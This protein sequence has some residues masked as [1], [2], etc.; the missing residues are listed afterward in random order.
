MRPAGIG[1]FEKRED[2]R[3]NVYSFEQKEIAF[4]EPFTGIFKANSKAWDYFQAQPAYYRK[5]A[6][7]WVISAKQEATKQKR[8]ETL[9]ADSVAGLHVKQLRRPEKK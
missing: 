5:A 2:A 8:L 3:S 7:W 1:A 6:T 4:D 9:I